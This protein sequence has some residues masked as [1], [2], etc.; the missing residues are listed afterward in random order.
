MYGKDIPEAHSL[1]DDS[2]LSFYFQSAVVSDSVLP[3]YFFSTVLGFKIL[4]VF[5][6]S[7]SRTTVLLISDDCLTV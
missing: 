1:N 7:I 2:F 5:N 4:K 3:F 6:L